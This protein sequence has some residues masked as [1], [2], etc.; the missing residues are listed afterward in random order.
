M[1]STLLGIFT[2]PASARTSHEQMLYNWMQNLVHANEINLHQIALNSFLSWQA[3]PCHFGLD[4]AIAIA[5]N[6][7]YDG[8]PY[9]FATETDVVGAQVPVG[10]YFT[11]YGLV[12]S[13]GAPM[14]TFPYFGGLVVGAGVDVA[15][16]A[17]NLFG[18]G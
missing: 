18:S 11:A 9:C 6:P 16:L 10:S 13:Y 14:D 7:S 3:D 17:G 2:K 4:P 12:K 15:E 5:A 1:M 8:N